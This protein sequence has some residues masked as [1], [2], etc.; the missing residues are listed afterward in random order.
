MTG[1]RSDARQGWELRILQILAF[2]PNNREDLERFQEKMP[3]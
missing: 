3:I 1:G 2:V